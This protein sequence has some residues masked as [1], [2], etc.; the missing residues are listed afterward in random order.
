[1]SREDRIQRADECRKICCARST[2]A[3]AATDAAKRHLRPDQLAIVVVGDAG[4]VAAD[5]EASGV[6]TIVPGEPVA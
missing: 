6:G 5:L 3:E 4:K 2:T 1:M